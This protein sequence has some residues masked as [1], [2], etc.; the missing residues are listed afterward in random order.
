[1]VDTFDLNAKHCEEIWIELKTLGNKQRILGAIYKHP[2]SDISEFSHKLEC[3]LSKLSKSTKNYFFSGDVNI[4]LSRDNQEAIEIYKSAINSL[5]CN[6]YIDNAT[7]VTVT[8]ASL[9]DHFYSNNCLHEITSYILLNDLCDHF[10]IKTRVKNA[11]ALKTSNAK[12]MYA[13]NTRKF[14]LENFLS[15]LDNCLLKFESYFNDFFVDKQPNANVLCDEFIDIFNRTL[16]KH[17]PLRKLTKRERKLKEKPWITKGILT[18][19]KSK[20]KLY[21][22]SLKTKTD[23]SIRI[24]KK[25]RNKLTHIKKLSKS[26]TIVNK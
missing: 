3:C 7:R 22:D 14:M 19:I 21:K 26:N 10:P 25:Y 12:S 4:D 15:D 5:G 23:E 13:R 18:S 16:D 1:M 8:S 20:N 9:I 6:Q 2:K 24:Y 11:K 17:A